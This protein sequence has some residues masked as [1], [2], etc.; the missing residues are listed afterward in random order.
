MSLNKLALIRYKTIDQCL[1]N[2]ARKWTLEDLIEKVS[3]ALYEYEGIRGGVSKRTIQLDIQTMRSDKLGYTAPIVV[4]ERKFYTYEDPKFSITQSKLTP[5]DLDKMN[6]AVGILKQLSGFSQVGELGEVITRLE[7]DLRRNRNEGPAIIQFES[8]PLLKGL[9]WLD[10]LYRAIATKQALLID[11]QSFK[12]REASQ[13]I[14]YPY[15]LKEYRNRW[16]LITR[17]KRHSHLLTLA[18]DRITALQELP[19]E[20]YHA[21]PNI[22]FDRYFDNVIGVTKSENAVA[23]KI[24]LEANR[25]VRPYI[26]TKPVHASQSILKD[27]PEQFIFMIEVILNFELE[28]EILSFGEQLKVLAPRSLVKRITGRLERAK[29]QYNATP[30]NATPA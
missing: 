22:E 15:L 20:L 27:T 17:N 16:F 11:Y 12:A 14:Y 21:H 6:E 9:D 8:N 28:R 7:S 10:P 26:L 2:R 1:R 29:Q 3:E 30:D 19:K 4:E 5:A 24:I 23:S 13:G 25:D 18:L